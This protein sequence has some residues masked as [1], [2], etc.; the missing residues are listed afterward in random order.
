MPVD[1]NGAAAAETP[2]APT[3]R[4]ALAAAAAVAR[5]RSAG[6]DAATDASHRAGGP[7]PRARPATLLQTTL[8]LIAGVCDVWSACSGH[9]VLI[10]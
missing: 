9:P 3:G 8:Q 1:S 2:A 5:Q 10:D 4:A 6:A 7:T